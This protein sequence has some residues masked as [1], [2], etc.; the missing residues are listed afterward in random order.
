MRI[1]T[2]KPEFWSHPVIA[3]LPDEV[4]LLALALLNYADDQGYFRATPSLV[5]SAC[6][7]FT[8][9]SVSTHGCLTTLE[10]AGWIEVRNHPEQGPI[11][12]VVNFTKHQAINRPSQSKLAGYWDSVS[13]HGGLTEDSVQ[14]QGTG[15][16][17]QG[18]G[19]REHDTHSRRFVKPTPE[20]VALHA[21]KI[22]LPTSEAERFV[23]YY[24]SNGWR[25]GRNPMRSWQAAL[26]NWR[27]NWEERRGTNTPHVKTDEEWE[28]GWK[29]PAQ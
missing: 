2:V 22:G 6:R 7:P 19:N 27:K 17:E 13:A 21:A 10:K 11:G 9:D 20:E 23:A 14:E 28:N 18:S 24:E 25:V 26:V 12:W 16:R 29:A 3:R 5:R 8:E 4:Q 1:R 15:N